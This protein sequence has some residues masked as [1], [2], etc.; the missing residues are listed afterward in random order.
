LQPQARLNTIGLELS[1]QLLILWQGANL[2]EDGLH[3]GSTQVDKDT[4]K[5]ILRFDRT[6]KF[7]HGFVQAMCHKGKDSFST[8]I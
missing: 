8:V 6:V 1:Q 2:V 5:Q 4:G 3:G 7:I